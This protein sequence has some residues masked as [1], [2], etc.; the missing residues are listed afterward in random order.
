MGPKETDLLFETYL[1]AALREKSLRHFTPT[2]V[3]EKAVDFLCHL[4]KN[5]ILDIGSGAG[6]FCIIG[7][8]RKRSDQFYGVEIRENLWAEAER[9]AKEWNLNNVHFLHQNITETSFRGYT[10]YYYFNP[11]YENMEPE[12][13]LNNDLE[14]HPNKYSSYS[15][16]VF[17]EMEKQPIG[18]RIATFHIPEGSLPS[19]YHL[20]DQYFDGSLQCFEKLM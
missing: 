7:A 19:E 3:I 8:K 4:R 5:K 2:E 14:F 18:T 9:I 6:K 17:R 15:G 12:N 20:I 13:S 11:F 16:R 1:P 10:G